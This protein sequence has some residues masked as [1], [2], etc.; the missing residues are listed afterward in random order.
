MKTE[1]NE[2]IQSNFAFDKHKLCYKTPKIVDIKINGVIQGG[3]IV[4]RPESLGGSVYVS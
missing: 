3:E 4:L 2:L 1:I